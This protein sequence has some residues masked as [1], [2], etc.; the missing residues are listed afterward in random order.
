MPLVIRRIIIKYLVYI[1]LS[2]VLFTG[3][4]AGRMEFV[5]VVQ[6]HKELTVETL[7]A[8]IASIQDD[9]EEMRSEGVLTPEMETEALNLVERLRMVESQSVVISDYVH[10]YIV[11]EELM[12]R[13][14]RARWTEGEVDNVKPFEENSQ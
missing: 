9:I 12:A 10:T 4:Q 2:L 1:L 13:L 14:L 3:C 11:D 8:V 5:Q 6:D 7:D